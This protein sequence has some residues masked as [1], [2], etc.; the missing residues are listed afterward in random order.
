[1]SVGEANIGVRPEPDL[2]GA[3]GARQGR[4]IMVL[5]RNTGHVSSIV[6][7]WSYRRHVD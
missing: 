3:F 1:M 5:G 4:S 7:A 6:L 2:T